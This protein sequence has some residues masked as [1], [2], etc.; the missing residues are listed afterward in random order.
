M[1]ESA[2]L[3]TEGVDLQAAWAVKRSFLM[4][5]AA[6]AA[7]MGTVT[8][9][10]AFA[11]P[12]F[13]GIGL[14]GTGVLFG[15]YCI[16][17]LLFAPLILAVFGQKKCLVAGL[18]QYCI[19]LLVY[20]LAELFGTGKTCP[21]IPGDCVPVATPIASVVLVV[22]GCFVGGFGSGY[23]WPAQGAYFTGSAKEYA[24]LAGIPETEATGKFSSYFATCFLFCEI[25]FKFIGAAIKQ[26]AGPVGTKAM[27]I[28]FLC[29]G[30]VSA[31]A[32]T[33]IRSI[34]EN[35]ERPEITAKLVTQKGAA[36]MKLLCSTP[37]MALMLPF[38]FAFGLSAAFL[39]GYIS[40]N[41]TKNVF[42]EKQYLI[43]YFAGIVAF[44]AM[45]VSF[46]GGKFIERTKLKSP[47][48]I[49]G[50]LAFAAMAGSFLL[51][52][53]PRGWSPTAT[54]SYIFLGLLYAAQ[55]VGRGVFESTNK[56]VI[57]DFFAADAPAAFA[58]VIWSSGG[59]TCLGYVLF[60]Y[61]PAKVQAGITTG[62]ALLGLV[63][64]MLAASIHN[65]R[66]HL[67]QL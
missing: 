16:S 32:M 59:S 51:F 29:I 64:Y 35:R 13:P 46:V 42:S 31:F 3:I 49:L 1:A 25:S 4:M 19:Y 11:G 2:P 66:G 45:V 24:R 7:N 60:P 40:T 9:V 34:D 22:C 47:L 56:A 17:A 12:D 43:G 41:V 28:C 14:T 26:T 50:C 10:I 38:E 37:K 58:N 39:N 54:S 5:C 21:A 55:G 62:M 53:D 15:A 23:L 44:V 52:K 36:A 48:M 8:T 27:Y 63:C 6:M 65:R 18:C 20:L 30:V 57:A 61:L 67:Q 33:R